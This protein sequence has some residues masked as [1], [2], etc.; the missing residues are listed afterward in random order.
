M[1]EIWRNHSEKSIPLIIHAS[2]HENCIVTDVLL[3][4]LFGCTIWWTNI[5]IR[6]LTSVTTESN[7]YYMNKNNS[8]LWQK[9]KLD[10]QMIAV[11]HFLIFGPWL[12]WAN[13]HASNDAGN[14]KIEWPWCKHYQ[15]LLSIT[16]TFT[17]SILISDINECTEGSAECD[18]N[19]DCENNEGSYDCNCKN[20]FSGDGKTCSGK[21]GNWISSVTYMF[22]LCTV[23]IYKRRQ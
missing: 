3:Q 13:Q 17:D 14:A 7:S 16:I 21:Q 23:F 10:R 15:C 5:F 22:N 6:T 11:A 2:Q 19:A 1:V 9:V 8:S 12:N 18:E 20:G 4:A